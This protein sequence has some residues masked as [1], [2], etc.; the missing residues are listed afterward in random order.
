MGA[1][2]FKERLSHDEAMGQ[3]MDQSRRYMLIRPEALMGIFR[4]LP[5]NSRDAALHALKASIAEQGG[6]SA[7][8]YVAMG[9]SGEALLSTITETAP[10]LGW[11]RWTIVR[12]GQTLR[13]DVENSPFAKGFGPSSRPVCHAV[14][15]MLEAVSGL[16]L[17]APVTASETACAATGAPRCEFE[18]H[19]GKV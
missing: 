5:E 11:G 7:R 6:D 13:L 16:V 1:S 4:N 18:A 19:T 2:T 15:G 3:W 12:N 17:G 14:A 9:G 10:M 8:A